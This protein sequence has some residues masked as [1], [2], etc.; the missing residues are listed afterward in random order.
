MASL[1]AQLDEK[2]EEV[3]LL[4]EVTRRVAASPDV[5]AMLQ[6]IAAMAVRLTGT[7]TATIYLL[8]RDSTLSLHAVYG[9]PSGAVGRVSLS[10]QEGITGWVARELHPVAIE[11]GAWKDPRFKALPEMRDEPCESFLSVPMVVQSEVLGVLNVKSSAPRSYPERT[12]RILQ[13]VASQAAAAVQGMRLQEDM[14]LRGTQ[15]SAI[16]EVSKTITSNLYLEEILQLIVAMTAQNFRFRLCSI[17]LLDEEKQELVIKATQSRLQDYVSKPNLRVGESVA[18]R[19]IQDRQVHYVVDVRRSPGYRFPDIAEKAGLCS[20]VCVPLIS[21]E[22]AIGV[23]NCYTSRPRQ[24]SE[25]EFEALRTVAN[26]VAIAIENAKLMVRSAV[27]QEMHHR[28]KNSLQTVASL[29]RLQMHRRDEG[30][31]EQVLQECVN[32]IITIAAVHDLLTREELD[33]VSIR[34]IA[35]TILNLTGRT[36][37]RPGQ[38]VDFRVTGDE[39]ALPAARASSLALILNELVQNAF[40]H[41]LRDGSTGTIE[42]EFAREADAVRLVVSNDGLPLAEGFD[43]RTGG[44]LGL[45]IVETL[46]RNDLGGRFRLER[47]EV[48]RACVTFPLQ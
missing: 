4:Q 21:R 17:M 16:S 9:E 38:K 3:E 23:L 7:E 15:L 42:V 32:R 8:E 48:T 43:P 13:S 11:S 12:V 30:P 1:R 27:I 29:L 6:Y 31:V 14:Q 41:G 24:F 26:Q 36:H 37:L 33:Q 44:S 25:P 47:G 46:T 39:I 5:S 22:R 28:V 10:T 2:S 40:E 35:Q 18:G 34:R 20:M 19:A 45:Q